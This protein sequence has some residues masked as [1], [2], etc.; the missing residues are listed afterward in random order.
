MIFVMAARH[1]LVFGTKVFE[2]FCN[3]DTSVVCKFA[4]VK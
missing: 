3:F 1:H 2:S 4:V